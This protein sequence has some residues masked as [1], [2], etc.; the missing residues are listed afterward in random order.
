MSDNTTI[1]WAGLGLPRR[2]SWNPFRA[3]NKETGKTGHFCIKVNGRCTHCYAEAFNL[4]PYGTGIGYQAQNLKLVDLFVKDIDQPLRW[5]QPRGVFVNSM[6]D[7]WLPA[8]PDQWIDTALWV[9]I[10]SHWHR[11]AY[12]TKQPERMF[13]HLHGFMGQGKS[14]VTNIP[15]ELMTPTIA[16][17]FKSLQGPITFPPKHI[18]FGITIG[19]QEDADK[20]LPWVK[21]L[22]SLLGPEALIWISNE[23][24]TGLVDWSGFE[25][26]INWMVSGYESGRKAR[27]AHPDASRRT[28]DWCLRHNIPF[29]FKQWGD[30]WPIG[31][32]PIGFSDS[33]YLPAP[34]R[35][36]EATRR[37][38]VKTCVTHPA[39]GLITDFRPGAMLMFKVGK[40]VA[41]RSLDGRTWDEFPDLT[42]NLNQTAPLT[43]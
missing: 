21:A 4:G 32:M 10:L 20:F 29:F 7:T 5:R 28:R 2:A 15:S 13:L 3:R 27:A 11:H 16:K 12:L 35:D 25:G 33:L 42:T 23:P 14:R 19:A 36:P 18:W 22:R 34:K 30:W 31:Q 38:K 8:I 1:E 41:G 37:C 40:H 24:I 6:S 17:A 26:L 39:D 9:S 43:P